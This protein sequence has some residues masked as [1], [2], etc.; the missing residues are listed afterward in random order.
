MNDLQ[1]K[2]NF[3]RTRESQEQ[4]RLSFEELPSFESLKKKE[5]QRLRQIEKDIQ[6]FL[7]AKNR[8]VKQ[9]EDLHKKRDVLREK[10]LALR[11]EVAEQDAEIQEK[12]KRL[13]NIAS[14]RTSE[15][16]KSLSA[17]TEQ[18]KLE[19]AEVPIKK[20]NRDERPHSDE[21]S[22][23]QEKE[24]N[25]RLDDESFE[26]LHPTSDD[27]DQGI[28]EQQEG[29]RINSFE[30]PRKNQEKEAELA[31][32]AQISETEEEIAGLEKEKKQLEKRFDDNSFTLFGLRLNSESSD[33]AFKQQGVAK[34]ETAK[35]LSS[36]GK[37]KKYIKDLL[38]GK[39]NVS[40]E[41][42]ARSY[43]PEADGMEEA[44]KK[45]SVHEKLHSLN[46][47]GFEVPRSKGSGF[48]KKDLKRKVKNVHFGKRGDREIENILENLAF[49]LESGLEFS[50][51]IS[52][53]ERNIRSKKVAQVFAKVSLKV[54]QGKPFWE[55]MADEGFVSLD[56]IPL[57]KIGEETGT[58]VDKIKLVV[59]EKR[60][61]DRNR[62]NLKSLLFYPALVFT[63]T[64]IITTL[65][66]IFVLPRLA[67]IF[68]GL[69]AD[70]PAI[71]RFLINMGAWMEVYG[72]I[73]LPI[74]FFFLV[75][76]FY[77]V[78][79][80]KKTN[81]IGQNIVLRVPVIRDLVKNSQISTFCSGVSVMIASGIP[82][83][84]SLDLIEDALVYYR[85]KRLVY[86]LRLGIAEGKSFNETFR[87]R[88]VMVN[89][90]V[91][92]EVQDII[93]AGERSGNL[94]KVL[95][96][97]S[98]RV[99][100]QSETISKNLTNL[101]E[102]VL[103]IIIWAAVVFLAVAILLPIYNLVGDFSV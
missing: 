88:Q 81:F 65:M 25:K 56:R 67:E 49:L 100:A 93:V 42:I 71:T 68:S 54:R 90:L 44:G 46:A 34:N 17:A 84:K 40:E 86:F 7:K 95:R 5:I 101:L 64:L 74:F 70:L 43:E 61:R 59:E 79:I 102:P 2:P 91:P 18:S 14:L 58:L 77:F 60:Q 23:E 9:E 99:D 97:V 39:K 16:E 20:K 94:S 55:A 103:L 21:T 69:D 24:I 33:T 51:A 38:Q 62:S 3:S 48:A 1:V 27:L 72:F 85:Y 8:T 6:K 29:L 10:V 75:L 45:S 66:G 4:K 19:I 57:I 11:Q 92:Y 30:V 89:K 26:P 47:P 13:K 32:P 15:H 96:T 37:S 87:E 82:I 41:D 12:I 53:L 35:N 36:A 63:L 52:S 28:I 80:N 83:Y 73:A 22:L 50:S 78:F 76:G 31:G 98:E